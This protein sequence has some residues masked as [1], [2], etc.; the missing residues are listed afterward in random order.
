MDAATIPQTLQAAIEFFASPDNCDRFMVELR[1]PN[2]VACPVC[3]STNV[4]HLPNQNRWKCREKHPRAQFS[5]KVGT[6]MEDSPLPLKHWLLVFWMVSNC[7]NGISSY[8]IARA[9]G[10]TQ[11]SAWFM[12]H[13]ARLAMQA[14]DGGKLGGEVEVDETYIGGKARNMHPH[15][16]EKAIRGRGWAGKAAV[17]GL[18]QRH[19]G[20]GKSRVRLEVI[21]STRKHQLHTRVEKHVED[22]S[23]VYTDALKSYQNLSLYYQHQVID[24]AEAYVRGEVHTNGLEN[25][26]SLLKRAIRGTYVSV[27]PFH[28]FRYLDEQAFRFNERGETD[29]ERFVRTMR[30]IEGRRVQYKHLIASEEE[31][32]PE[33]ENEGY[34][35]EVF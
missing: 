21:P 8:E 2:G 14:K 18:L 31:A 11:K 20:K 34:N 26:W 23:A 9:T 22:G 12:L 24:H 13:R 28:L 7:K 10:V 16:R 30:Q 4:L 32:R 1:W 29:A 3:G 19:S 33:A 35:G 6:V 5:A 17:M 15:K 27:E 25:F